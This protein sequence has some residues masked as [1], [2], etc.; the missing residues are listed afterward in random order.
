MFPVMS[1][2]LVAHY[3]SLINFA[4]CDNCMNIGDVGSQVALQSHGKL[5]FTYHY[6]PNIVL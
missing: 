6:F 3:M 1:F 2:I 4:I 5:A